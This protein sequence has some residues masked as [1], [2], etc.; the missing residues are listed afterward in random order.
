MN[1][2]RYYFIDYKNCIAKN[3]IKLNAYYINNNLY[4]FIFSDKLC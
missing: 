1:V 2:L 4:L 3:K